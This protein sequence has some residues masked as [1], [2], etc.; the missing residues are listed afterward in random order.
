MTYGD[1]LA[2]R[3]ASK[4]ARDR[5]EAMVTEPR[6]TQRLDKALRIEVN[7]ISRRE[8]YCYTE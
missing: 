7:M 1:C 4:V 8:L 3:S 2:W 6:H 5:L